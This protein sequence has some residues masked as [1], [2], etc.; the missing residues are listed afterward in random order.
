MGDEPTKPLVDQA[1]RGD[2]RA[3]ETLLEKYLPG[4]RV[5]PPASAGAAG[6]ESSSDI[7]QSVCATLRVSTSS[8]AGRMRSAAGSSAALRKVADRAEHYRAGRR[9]VGRK[10]PAARRRRRSCG[11][12]PLPLL[13]ERASDARESPKVETAFDALT[14]EERSS[15]SHESSASAGRDQERLGKTEGAVRVMLHRALARVTDFL[16][17]P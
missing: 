17:T 14:T 9:D 12:L 15:D 3:I 7:T 5:R 8:V 13:P 10:S 11:V 6:E 1:A 2:S 16:G 4:L